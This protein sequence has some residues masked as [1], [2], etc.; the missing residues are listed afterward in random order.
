MGVS[1]DKRLKQCAIPLTAFS[2]VSAVTMMRMSCSEK[3]KWVK[4]EAVVSGG[5]SVLS[6]KWSFP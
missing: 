1:W 4:R 6:G 3:E 5:T 2:A